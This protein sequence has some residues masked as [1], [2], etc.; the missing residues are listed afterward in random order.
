MRT[1]ALIIA[2]VVLGFISPW[3]AGPDDGT[4]LFLWFNWL[5]IWADQLFM[6]EGWAALAL[7]VT[8]LAV[9]YLALF[10]VAA[11]LRRAVRVLFH[12]VRGPRHRAGLVR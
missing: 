6:L 10:A 8:V 9:Q 12:F 7:D 4:A 3:L 11:G 2:A 5:P 1:T